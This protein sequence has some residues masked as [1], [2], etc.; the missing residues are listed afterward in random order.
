MRGIFSF[1]KYVSTLRNLYLS[2]YVVS[3]TKRGVATHLSCVNARY[4]SS[5]VNRAWRVEQDFLGSLED[6]KGTRR[7][8]SVASPPAQKL[9]IELF[10]NEFARIDRKLI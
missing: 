1:Q 6:R 5:R 3:G 8:I 7:R 9:F 10:V 2:C 4:S